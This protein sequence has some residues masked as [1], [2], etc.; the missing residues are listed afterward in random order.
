MPTLARFSE[1]NFS[2]GGPTW[3]SAPAFLFAMV[4]SLY[5]DPFLTPW[6]FRRCARE[7]TLYY[8]SSLFLPKG[9]GISDSTSPKRV[10]TVPISATAVIFSLSTN[11]EVIIVTTGVK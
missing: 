9:S 1:K 5:N 11:A 3:T 2:E 6:L 8:F 10:S 7:G 4:N